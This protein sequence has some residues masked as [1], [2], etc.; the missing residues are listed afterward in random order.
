VAVAADTGR[1]KCTKRF[2]QNAKKTAKFLSN[3]EMT[4]RYTAKI[5]IQNVRTKAVR[6][7]SLS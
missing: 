4:G 5:V 1:G 7:K 6:I 3:P 2:V